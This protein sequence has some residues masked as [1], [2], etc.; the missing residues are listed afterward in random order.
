MRPVWIKEGNPAQVPF[1]EGW[2]ELTNEW[3][4]I[5]N[6]HFHSISAFHDVVQGLRSCPVEIEKT[7][8]MEPIRHVQRANIAN[9]TAEWIGD[10]FRNLDDRPVAT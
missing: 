3:V 5:A 9:D 2:C 10:P 4:A 7:V 6:L 1:F 8:L